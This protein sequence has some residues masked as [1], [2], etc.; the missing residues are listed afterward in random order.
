MSLLD[1]T[2]FPL[3]YLPGGFVGGYVVLGLAPHV[4]GQTDEVI[5]MLY[6]SSAAKDK[7]VPPRF[8]T[9]CIYVDNV[10]GWAYFSARN[11]FPVS[12]IWRVP[13]SKNT[14]AALHKL[15]AGYRSSASFPPEFDGG[16]ILLTMLSETMLELYLVQSARGLALTYKLHE[17][18]PA[19]SGTIPLISYVGVINSLKV[20][21]DL[22]SN[23][24]VNS[25]VVGLQF[26]ATVPIPRKFV[27]DAPAAFI[28]KALLLGCCFNKNDHLVMGLVPEV[29][30]VLH[31]PRNTQKR[32]IATGFC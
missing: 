31:L 10:A 7:Y 5:H 4:A 18:P 32:I 21:E 6:R 26:D 12:G 1:P 27:A 16:G 17:L 2:P 24:P 28:L 29:Y 30:V 11:G 14:M 8:S 13:H 22:R 3:P 25:Q 23:I 19:T 15:V 20:F 9:I